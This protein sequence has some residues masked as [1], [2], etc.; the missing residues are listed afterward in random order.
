MSDE[1]CIIKARKAYPHCAVSREFAVFISLF[2]LSNVTVVCRRERRD[3]V[4]E[5][6]RLWEPQTQ[7]GNEGA[8]AECAVTHG[9]CC[10][11]FCDN[12]KCK[13][14]KVRLWCKHPVQILNVNGWI[15]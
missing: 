1:C 7:P 4:L 9:N 12:K 3:S 2:S 11:I 14:K 5:Y 13:Y 6:S 8:G 15:Q 10:F